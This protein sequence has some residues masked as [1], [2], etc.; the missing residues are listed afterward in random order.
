MSSV[1][2]SAGHRAFVVM[3]VSGCGKS[4]VGSLLAARLGATF[5]EGDTFHPPANIR[6]MSGGSA[7]TDADRWPWLDA[8]GAAMRAAL[9]GG[10][11]CSCSALR[12]A[13]RQW[14]R[15]WVSDIAFIHLAGSRDVIQ[16]RLEQRQGHFMPPGLLDSQLSTLELPKGEAGVYR[17][18]IDRPLPELVE[19][20]AASVAPAEL[21][22]LDF[23]AKDQGSVSL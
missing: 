5:L 10:V 19:D 7:L 12:F 23:L 4:T 8:I 9:P 1:G 22:K 3:G 13:Y 16:Q 2:E 6:K 21:A 11:V 17:F 20:V 14:L 15:D 18:D